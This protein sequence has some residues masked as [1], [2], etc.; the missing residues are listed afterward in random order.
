MPANTVR[1][2]KVSLLVHNRSSATDE[3]QK[4]EETSSISRPRLPSASQ[5][6]LH[7]TATQTETY[8]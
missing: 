4:Q 2:V 5:V 7:A 1:T 3:E 8:A 6:D